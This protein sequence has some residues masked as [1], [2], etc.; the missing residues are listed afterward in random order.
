MN[1]VRLNPL[2]SAWLFTEARATPTTL[3]AFCSS[4]Y[5]RARPGLHAQADDRVPQ[6]PGVQPA[7]ERRLKY[8]FNKN[9][10]PV[11][12]EDDDIDLEYHVRHSALPWPGS[13]RNWANWFG[14]LQSTPLDLSRPPWECTIIEGLRAVLRCSSNAPLAD[15]RR[16]RNEVAAAGMSPDRAK[17]VALPPFWAAGSESG[18]GENVTPAADRRHAA[19]RRYRPCAVR[20][21]LF[22]NWSR[23]SPKCSSAWVIPARA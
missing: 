8:A 4:G 19:A 21:R 3:V 13:E 12:I 17:S 15:R 10:M 7:M 11:W 20:Y 5:Q 1:S 23:P 6:P 14:R 22:R 9:P 18:R 16:E 2:D